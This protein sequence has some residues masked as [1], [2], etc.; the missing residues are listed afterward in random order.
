MQKKEKE[1]TNSNPKSEAS[2]T[3]NKKQNPAV[4][5][6]P[7]N[8][9]ENTVKKPIVKNKEVKVIQEDYKKFTIITI[10]IDD[11]KY[12]YRKEEFNFSTFYYKDGVSI[13]ADTYENETK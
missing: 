4:V 6:Q 1:N 3:E 11:L 10:T 5:A 7:E 13:G 8:N 12:V 9:L 2:T